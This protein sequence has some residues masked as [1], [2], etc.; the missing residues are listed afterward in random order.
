MEER[1]YSDVSDMRCA[2]AS[3]TRSKQWRRKVAPDSTAII[4]GTH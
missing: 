1:P 3:P 4:P 2:V